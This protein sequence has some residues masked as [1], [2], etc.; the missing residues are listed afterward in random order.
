MIQGVLV[1]LS[2]T[3][4]KRSSDDTRSVPHVYL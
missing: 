2:I 1:F 4:Y 3:V